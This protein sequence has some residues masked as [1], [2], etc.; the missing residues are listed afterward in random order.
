M[1][2][3]KIHVKIIC[4]YLKYYFKYMYFKILP[5]T[6]Y[7]YYFPRPQNTCIILAFEVK[8]RAFGR[9]GTAHIIHNATIA[10]FNPPYLTHITL[11]NRT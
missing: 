10:H 4:M 7:L 1:I 11:R 5:I 2:V 3:F 9:L 6:V 8:L